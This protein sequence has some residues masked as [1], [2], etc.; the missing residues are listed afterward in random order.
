MTDE[1]RLGK[2]FGPDELAI[3]GTG[4]DIWA[5]IRVPR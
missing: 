4:G 1:E 2:V 3:E 5:E